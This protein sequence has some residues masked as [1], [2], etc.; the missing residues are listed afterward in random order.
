M[1]RRIPQYWTWRFLLGFFFQTTPAAILTPL[2]TLT[3]AERGVEAWIIG[4]LAATGSISYMLALAATPGLVRRYGQR[5]VFRAALALGAMALVGLV[6]VAHPLPL[7][8]CFALAGFTA[9]LR[10]TLA[11]SWAPALALPERRGRVMALFQTSIG[12]ALFAGAG[13]L[14]LTG[15][16]GPAPRA[17]ALATG[18]AAL[19]LLWPMP[20]PAAARATPL[21]AGLRGALAQVGPL[22]FGMAL[23]GGLFESGLSVA[24]PLYG[25]QVGIGSS[26]AT[27]IVTA[28]GLGSLAQYP[29]GALA[30][31][32]PWRQVILGTT[33]AIALSALLLPLA[34]GAP[35]L[36]LL[37]GVVW[38]GA[39]GG[40]Y[41][42]ATI[43]NSAR[44]RGERLISA[45]A[46]TQFAY[47]IGD[48]S[49]P[50][51]G[52]LALDLAPGFGLPALVI[53]AGLLGLGLIL[54]VTESGQ[55]SLPPASPAPGRAEA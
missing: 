46:V 15:I 52:G 28:M 41:T 40:L 38:G 34:H 13:S 22:A 42:L 16:H 19:V 20:V 48:A 17:L 29:F 7:A 35:W 49:G 23:L 47:M 43:R 50:A 14:L 18:L 54:G 37:L 5:S 39:G 24:L 3:L 44:L 12:A 53:G 32:W 26:L 30:D 51:I 33:A 36:L 27:G 1:L 45:S 4:S 11:E 8:G 10:F 21:K 9:G 6:L 2:L 31:R 55:R 25:L